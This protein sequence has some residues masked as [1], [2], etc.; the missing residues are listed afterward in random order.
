MQGI[1]TTVQSIF[2]EARGTIA[3]MPITVG[4]GLLIAIEGIDGAGKTTQANALAE[5]LAVVGLQVVTS[6]EPTNGPW[7]QKLRSSAANGRMSAEDEL[8]AFIE[9]RRE[10][11]RD[12][13]RPSLDAGKVVILDR[14]Y[15]STAAYQGARGMD[16]RAIIQQNEGFAPEP[17]LLVLLSVDPKVGMSRI[18]ERGD[19]ANLFEREDLLATSAA[20]FGEIDK[21]YLLRLDGQRAKNELTGAVLQHL[22]RGALFDRLCFKR[23]YKSECEPAFCAYQIDGSCNYLHMGPLAPVFGEITGNL[24]LSP[25]EQ[26]LGVAKLLRGNPR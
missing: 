16:W 24:A 1:P 15:F 13:I 9:D 22:Y 12:I 19:S 18:A 7:G 25:A 21:P 8:A 23:H 10:H 20:I 26:A 14:Y 2:S 4:R 6:K 5:R 11:V 17:D 3:A